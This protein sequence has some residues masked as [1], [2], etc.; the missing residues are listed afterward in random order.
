MERHKIPYG[1][2]L[3]VKNDT[4]V[5]TGD[6]VAKWDPHTHPIIAE[7][8][9]FIQFV[10]LDE[11][12]TVSRQT[13]ET[14]GLTSTVVLS[15]DQRDSSDQNRPMIRIVDEKGESVCL[16]GTNSFANY[17]LSDGSI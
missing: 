15:S 4:D 6:I 1:T 14:T 13:D 17:F 8:S 7:V 9:G 2:T 10:N 11:G 12:R 5:K 3:L 16:P